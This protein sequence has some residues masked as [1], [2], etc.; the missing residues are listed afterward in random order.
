MI[1]DGTFNILLAGRDT[2]HPSAR[3]VRTK[4]NPDAYRWFDSDRGSHAR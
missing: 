1:R 3:H 4:L 2:V